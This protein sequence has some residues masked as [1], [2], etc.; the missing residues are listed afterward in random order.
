MRVRVRRATRR[1]P[2]KSTVHMVH[3][4]S[5]YEGVSFYEVAEVKDPEEDKWYVFDLKGRWV[6]AEGGQDMGSMVAVAD[7]WYFF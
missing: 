7:R 4:L 3:G 6:A 2:A 5:S 1:P